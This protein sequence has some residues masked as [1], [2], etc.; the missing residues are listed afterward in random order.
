MSR[1]RTGLVA[2]AAVAVLVA[3]GASA[4]GE[5]SPREVATDYAEAYFG[6]DL[7]AACGLWGPDYRAALL[8]AYAADDEDPPADC[9]E[10]GAQQGDAAEA[11]PDEAFAMSVGE[12]RVDGTQAVVALQASGGAESARW[13]QAMEVELREQDGR[14]WVTGFRP[15]DGDRPG[16]A[17][18]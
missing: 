9:D 14:W 12:A 17:G 2:A 1:R 16:E 4:L 10:L 13:Q 6:G 3:L 7:V 5:P 8:P 18:G 15:P 11:W